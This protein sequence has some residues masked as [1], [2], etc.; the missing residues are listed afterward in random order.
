LLARVMNVEART[1]GVPTGN[2]DYLAALHGG[3]AAYHHELDGTRRERLRIPHGLERRLVLAYT[4]EPRSS[5]YSNWDMF[6]RFCDGEPKARRRLEAIAAIAREMVD[7]VRLGDVEAVGRLVGEE[8]R[9]R[10]GLAPSVATPALLRADKAARSAGALGLKVCGAGGGGCVVA[11]AR[12]GNADAVRAALTS[13][14]A[15]PLPARISRRGVVVQAVS[16]RATESR[17]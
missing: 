5:G 11:V 3:L 17:R 2:Q 12:D 15:V 7:A 16:G 8:G 4:G 13:V 10:L 1:L 6:R 9:L 14:G